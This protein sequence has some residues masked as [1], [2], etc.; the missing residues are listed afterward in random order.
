MVN[1]PL[2]SICIPTYNVENF[3]Q[4]TLN[5]CL[6]Q[7][8]KNIEIIISDNCSTDK[9]VSLIKDYGDPRIKI[10][11]N[12]VNEGLLFNYKKVLSYATGKYISLLSA[13]DGMEPETVAKAVFVLEAP[14]NKDIVL[15]NTYIQVINSEGKKIFNKKSP[16]GGGRISSY[17]A[18]RS[19]FLFG[20]NVLGEPNGSLF[21]KSAYDK[22]PEPK[23]LNGNSWTIDIDIKLELLL[24]GDAFTI[25]EYLGKFRLSDQSTSVSNLKLV[26]AKLFREYAYRVYRDRRYGLSSILVVTATVNSLIL[27]LAR[28]IFYLIFNRESGSKKNS[29][30]EITN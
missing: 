22:I 29:S 27:E 14:E 28:N 18:I 30:N 25:P 21:R 17:R 8:Y 9:T 19:N 15:I 6:N 10:F 5:A 24:Q 11:S 4:E 26:Q 12:S 3:I 7:T 23:F 2:V 13:D 16:F 1:Q 20:T